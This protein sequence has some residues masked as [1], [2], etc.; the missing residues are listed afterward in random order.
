MKNKYSILFVIISIIFF[1]F[2][3]FTGVQIISNSTSFFKKFFE[4]YNIYDKRRISVDDSVYVIDTL[5][6]YME[7]KNDTIKLDRTILKFSSYS[8]REIKHMVDVKNIYKTFKILRNIS[9]VIYICIL[10]LYIK[11]APKIKIFKYSI[12]SFIITNIIFLGCSITIIYNFDAVWR[13]F[14]KI[15]FTNDLWLL[16][17]S[18]DLI[19][20]ICSNEMFKTIAIS[21][22][23]IYFI[24]CVLYLS[25]VFIYQK[26]VVNKK[27]LTL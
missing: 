17:F 11:K 13:N 12:I 2:M 18:E 21:S 4:E 5:V 24:I 27:V 26:K 19:I 15:I 25:A 7:G 1:V 10:F 22:Y 3:Y 8:T 23:Y 6:D 14:H 20:N 16:N 9:C